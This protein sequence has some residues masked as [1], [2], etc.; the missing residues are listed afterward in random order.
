LATSAV[1]RL[2]NARIPREDITIEMSSRVRVALILAWLTIF[3]VMPARSA[4]GLDLEQAIKRLDLVRPARTRTAVDFSVGLHP[5]GTFRLSEQRGKVVLLN[6]WA[7]WCAPCLE[8]MPAI[9]RL[10]ERYRDRGLI[11][12][13]VSVDARTQPVV[14]FVTRHKLGFSVGL[15]PKSEVATLY[16]ARALPSTF[17]IDRDGG[18]AALALGPRIWDGEAAHALIESLTP[19]Q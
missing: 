19:G 9:G 8:E 12:L 6:F 14:S 7:T 10:W 16:G 1:D 2:E 3:V 11:V 18:L 15:D 4:V 13:A 17:I 5:D